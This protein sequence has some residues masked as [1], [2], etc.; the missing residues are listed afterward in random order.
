[1]DLGVTEAQDYQRRYGNLTD[2]IGRQIN[3]EDKVFA[4]RESNYANKV[5]MQGKIN[6]NRQAAWG[7]IAN[8]GFGL[9]NFGLA[10]G[11]EMAS[12]ALGGLFQG[13]LPGPGLQGPQINQF[14]L[15]QALGNLPGT[16]SSPFA[17]GQMPGGYM[18]I[19]YG[20]PRIGPR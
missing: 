11:G 4:D 3:E 5:A 13:R 1:M 8:M 10:G 19:T 12:Q 18:P 20:M 15:Q 7:D 17:G 16:Q 14:G 9:A 2:A 6:E